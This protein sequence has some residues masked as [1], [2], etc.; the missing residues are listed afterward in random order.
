MWHEW[1]V[2]TDDFMMMWFTLFV[3]LVS[4]CLAWASHAHVHG[5]CAL[6]KYGV[7]KYPSGLVCMHADSNLE[8]ITSSHFQVLNI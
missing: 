3:N 1:N 5:T 2:N 6:I 4:S 7:L 8:K